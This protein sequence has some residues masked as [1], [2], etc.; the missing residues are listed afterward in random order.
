LIVIGGSRGASGRSACPRDTDIGATIS[1]GINA[2]V[3]DKGIDILGTRTTSGV[4]LDLVRLMEVSLGEDGD[5]G[6][7]DEG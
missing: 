5:D 2:D 1:E 4:G 3:S 6:D 7:G